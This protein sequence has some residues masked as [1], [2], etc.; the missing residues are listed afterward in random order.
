MRKQ[1]L[2]NIHGLGLVD[3]SETDDKLLRYAAE[4]IWLDGTFSSYSEATVSATVDDGGRKV[5][6]IWIFLS[7][8]EVCIDQP[9]ESYVHYGVGLHTCLGKEASIK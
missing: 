9:L 6:I 2:P 3:T 5:V 1:H 8:N 4:G 7:P